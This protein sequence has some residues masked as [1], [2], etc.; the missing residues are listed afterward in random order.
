MARRPK[1][2]LTVDGED[3]SKASWRFKRKKSAAT[4][5][6]VARTAQ[7]NP[8]PQCID[9]HSSKA[10]VLGQDYTTTQPKTMANS[11]KGEGSPRVCVAASYTELYQCVGNAAISHSS[12]AD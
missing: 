1:V 7:G 3:G 10:V 11:K 6:G 5:G 2:D 4:S 8:P 9:R 12:D